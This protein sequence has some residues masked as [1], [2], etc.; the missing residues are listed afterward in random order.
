MSNDS[1]GGFG[2]WLVIGVISV[3]ALVYFKPQCFRTPAQVP[4]SA[5]VR[6]S[7]VGMGN[8]VQIRNTS[9]KTL[10]DV[11]VTARNSGL[12]Q[13]AYYTVG[14]LDSYDSVEIG[15]LEWNWTVVRNET[16]S[17]SA[18]GFLPTVFSSEQLG[19]K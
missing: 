8:V 3:A 17:V 10:F 19:V 7:L 2:G 5:S 4:V 18:D 15:W 16:I 1:E 12:N 14:T 13:T 11:V 6:A 9:G